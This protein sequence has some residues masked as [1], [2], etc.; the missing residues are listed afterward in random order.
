MRLISTWNLAWLVDINAPL[1]MFESD[2]KG[3]RELV[4]FALN[5]KLS[6]PPAL[7]F[8]STIGVW[9]GMHLRITSTI[10][11][12]NELFCIPFTVPKEA[13]SMPEGPIDDPSISSMSGYPESKWIAEHVLHEAALNTPLRTVVVRVGQMSGGLNGAWNP[14]QWVPSIVKSGLSLDCLPSGNDVSTVAWS[15]FVHHH[16]AAEMFR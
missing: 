3:T 9:R 10:A 15:S 7:L 8:I 16:D 6:S 12:I 13:I 2:I 14:I 11:P 5:S 1:A 4:N